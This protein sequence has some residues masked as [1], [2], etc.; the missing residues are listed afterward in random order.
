[1]EWKKYKYIFENE[2][3]TLFETNILA[4]MHEYIEY[5]QETRDEL[6]FQNIYETMSYVVIHFAGYTLMILK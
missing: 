4:E 6:I 3:E 1:M 2:H 5:F